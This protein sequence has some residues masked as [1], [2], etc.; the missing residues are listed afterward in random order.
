MIWKPKTIPTFNSES[1]TG[2]KGN[3]DYPSGTPSIEGNWTETLYNTRGEFSDF[4]DACWGEPGKY[5]FNDTYL[6]REPALKFQRDGRFCDFEEGTESYKRFWAFEKKKIGQGIIIN[7]RYIPGEYY[8]YMNYTPIMDAL[9]GTTDF[10][11]AWDSDYHFYLYCWRANI[12][13]LNAGV[14][15]ARRKGMEQPISELILTNEGF[16]PFSDISVG[17]LVA[18]PSGTYTPVVEIYEHPNKDVYEVT[19]MDGR[20]VKCG[21][22][23]L[24]TVYD[25]RAVKNKTLNIQEMLEIGLSSPTNKGKNV[26]YRFAV[27]DIEPVEY[28]QP[29]FLSVPS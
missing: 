13:N 23:H 20:K 8:F 1:L 19:F 5:G 6:W 16:K 15:K 17:T 4:L 9:K 29:L 3:D 25:K 18:T 14:V 27:P 22:E 12:R 11:D 21:L 10:A 24:W 2:F 28:L 7:G 26:A